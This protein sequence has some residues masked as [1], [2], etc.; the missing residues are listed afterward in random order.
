MMAGSGTQ[1]FMTWLIESPK[2]TSDA[3]F[4]MILVTCARTR[5]VRDML[6]S[7]RA[8]AAYED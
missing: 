7:G 2:Y 3:L 8:K 5:D 4:V 1:H 6:A